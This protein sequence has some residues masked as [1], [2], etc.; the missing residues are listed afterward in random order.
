[1][2]EG[3]HDSKI[4]KNSMNS[5]NNKNPD[6]DTDNFLPELKILI[7][8]NND[9]VIEDENIKLKNYVGVKKS[10]KNKFKLINKSTAGEEKLISE[11]YFHKTLIEKGILPSVEAGLVLAL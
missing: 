2:L 7:N 3:D 5:S 11:V 10:D 1:M 8:I 4:T 6:Y 9:L